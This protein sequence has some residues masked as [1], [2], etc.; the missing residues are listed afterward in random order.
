MKNKTK[1]NTEQER[2]ILNKFKELKKLNLPFEK[3]F[4]RDNKIIREL[5]SFYNK[6]GF[7]ESRNIN[8]NLNEKQIKTK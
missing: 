8:L 3:M 6:Y 7:P 1:I 4:K 2:I 5:K